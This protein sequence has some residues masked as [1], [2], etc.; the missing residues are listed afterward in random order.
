MAIWGKDD[1]YKRLGREFDKQRRHLVEKRR[2]GMFGFYVVEDRE[3]GRVKA[4]V[5]ADGEVEYMV[6]DGVLYPYEFD[7]L[8]ELREYVEGGGE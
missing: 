5:D 8:L 2:S 6:E 7:Q 3:R 1:A 4:R